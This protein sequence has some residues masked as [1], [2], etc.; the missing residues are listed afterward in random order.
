[1]PTLQL[2]LTPPQPAP[3]IAALARGLTAL[4]TRILAKREEVTALLV[5]EV[6]AGRW[7]I[8]GEPP[9]RATARLEISVTAGTNTLRDK[10]AFIAA[11][12]RELQQQLGPL[13]DASYVVVRELPASDW[14]YG[15]STQA[16]R[17]LASAAEG[18]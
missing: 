8:A 3:R 13:E 5:D 4:S 15:G 6:A 12:F 14:G 9:Q 10:E 2:Q 18:L 16:A 1:M 7:F 17:R 11:A